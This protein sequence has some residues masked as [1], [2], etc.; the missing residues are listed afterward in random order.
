MVV[1]LWRIKKVFLE[2]R[3]TRHKDKENRAPQLGC[4]LSELKLTDISGYCT[5]DLPAAHLGN[6]NPEV[7]YVVKPHPEVDYIVNRIPR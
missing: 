5:H 1:F 7:D 3:L 2:S 6:R 4:H